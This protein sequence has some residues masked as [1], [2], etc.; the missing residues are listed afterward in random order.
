MEKKELMPSDFARVKWVMYREQIC[1]VVGF[2]SDCHSIRVFSHDWATPKWIQTKYCT[3][4]LRQMDD[5]TVEEVREYGDKC[6]YREFPIKY[7]LGDP[8]EAYVP[9]IE[10]YDYLDSI[11]VDCRGWIDAGLAI[12]AA[13]LGDRNPYIK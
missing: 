11:G 6:V 7:G 10:A 1:E 3:P 9:E 12:D 13:T 4:I 5:M 2:C 8:A